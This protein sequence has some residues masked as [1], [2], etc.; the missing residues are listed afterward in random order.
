MSECTAMMWVDE[1]KE[2]VDR[3]EERADVCVYACK[4]ARRLRKGGKEARE[5]REV[6]F[7][8]CFE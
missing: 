6:R 7:R 1:G 3:R 2:V 5:C 8:S 4:F